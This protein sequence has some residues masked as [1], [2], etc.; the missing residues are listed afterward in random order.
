[1]ALQKETKLKI[2]LGSLKREN[3]N[4]NQSFRKFVN[5]NLIEKCLNFIAS[6][7]KLSN[8]DEIQQRNIYV[9]LFVFLR[10]FI[11]FDY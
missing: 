4:E 7:L 3:L 10:K 6:R 9:S 5:N 11:L 1:M 2:F 8:A